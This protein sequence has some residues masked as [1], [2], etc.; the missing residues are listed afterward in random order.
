MIVVKRHVSA[1]LAFVTYYWLVI[2]TLLMR[3]L[4]RDYAITGLVVGG[5]KK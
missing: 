2:L 3:Y 4:V 5:D 1:L